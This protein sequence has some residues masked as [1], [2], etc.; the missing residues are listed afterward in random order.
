MVAVGP[1]DV[2]GVPLPAERATWRIPASSR[3]AAVWAVD[4]AR[5]Q[6]RDPLGAGQRPLHRDVVVAA[7]GTAGG[8]AG[9]QLGVLRER[10]PRARQL[11][12][13]AAIDARVVAVPVGVERARHDDVRG[14]GAFGERAQRAGLLGARAAGE[15]VDDRLWPG[16]LRWGAGREQFGAVA[17]QVLDGGERRRLVRAG[18]REHDLV[19]GLEQVRD[20]GPPDRAGASDEQH[21]HGLEAS[22]E[23]ATGAAAAGRYG[24][25]R[26][27]LFKA[28]D[29]PTAAAEEW[30]HIVEEKL[31][32]VDPFGGVPDRVAAADI[33]AVR[34]AA[35]PAPRDGR[36]GTFAAWTGTCTRSTS[37]RMAVE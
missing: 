32:P 6:D 8:R 34:V 26:A 11:G 16:P 21:A 36:S 33:G 10:Q 35:R 28:S 9:S 5:A 3:S 24:E 23:C 37:S 15:R 12:G 18:M 4:C 17:V 19:A 22:V 27:V 25:G 14:A 13:R 7:G 1:R 20:R 31:G 29:E 30:Q 2:L